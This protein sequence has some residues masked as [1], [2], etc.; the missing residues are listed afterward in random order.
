V[1]YHHF[2]CAVP[3]TD[4]LHL[5]KQLAGQPGCSGVLDLGSGNGYWTHCLRRAGLE[6]MA[7][8]NGDAV[9][10]TMWVGDTVKADAAAYLQ[11]NGGG[12]DKVV[13]MVY[14]VVSGEWMR[15]VLAAFKGEYVA[16][17]GTQCRNGFTGF[18]DITVRE[19]TEG[20]DAEGK[21]WEVV[22]QVPTPSFAGKDEAIFVLK[23]KQS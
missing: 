18:R 20:D 13:L 21:K 12:A 1:L 5:I 16:V 6:C 2:G 11:K 22:S 4:A 15:G 7:V 23:R 14:P 8:D 3:S 19:W 10:R 17:V 9:W